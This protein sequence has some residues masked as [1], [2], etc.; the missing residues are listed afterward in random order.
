MKDSGIQTRKMGK[1]NKAG[2]MGVSMSR[3]GDCAQRNCIG[4]R[5]GFGIETK[6]NQIQYQGYWCRNRRNGQGLETFSDRYSYQ[7]EWTDSFKHGKGTENWPNFMTEKAYLEID[8][9]DYLL[10]N[11][12][13]IEIMKNLSN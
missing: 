3:D 12:H 6:P 9:L 7:G 4:E 11:N 5:D 10:L 1:G 2:K 13:I 8:Q